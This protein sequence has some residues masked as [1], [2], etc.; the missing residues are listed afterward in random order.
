MFLACF[1]SYNETG[2]AKPMAPSYESRPI[3]QA[4]YWPHGNPRVTK[5]YDRTSDQIALDEIGKIRI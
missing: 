2:G 1:V 3:C 5:L 4:W